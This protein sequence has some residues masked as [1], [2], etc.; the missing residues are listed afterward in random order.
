MDRSDL[1]RRTAVPFFFVLQLVA[2]FINPLTGGRYGKDVSPS[3]C[4]VVI[5]THLP[6]VI[7]VCDNTNEPLSSFSCRLATRRRKCRQPSRSSH[8]AFFS[9]SG[10]SSTFSSHFTAQPS[11][12]LAG[13]QMRPCVV[14]DGGSL[15]GWR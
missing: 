5:A 15:R 1:L 13:K 6:H 12:S 8:L 14:R 9:R 7:D 2:V 10:R 11:S 3:F 4:E